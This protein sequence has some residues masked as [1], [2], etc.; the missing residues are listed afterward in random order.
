MKNNKKL[1]N[2]IPIIKF[3][4]IIILTL[5]SDVVLVVSTLMLINNASKWFYLLAFVILFMHFVCFD[6]AI[7]R[8]DIE[9]NKYMRILK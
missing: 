2:D 7:I 6:Y 8:Y 5:I 3:S 1:I 9:T 4:V